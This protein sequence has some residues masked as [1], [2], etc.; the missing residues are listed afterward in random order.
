MDARPRML[1]PEQGKAQLRRNR[2]SQPDFRANCPGNPRESVPIPVQ[3]MYDPRNV[4][5]PHQ[6][7]MGRAI[8]DQPSAPS[9]PDLPH[10]GDPHHSSFAPSLSGQHF[11]SPILALCCRPVRTGMD[12][13]IHRPRL[14][15]QTAGV[16][17]RLAL[18]LRRRALV[19]GENQRQSL[20]T[21]FTEGCAILI[22]RFM[23]QRAGY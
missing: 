2:P 19:V 17:S 10:A 11:R 21:I 15:R 12:P 18:S 14:R 6:R 16:L 23:R 13:P 9:Q 3:P 7:A 20:R 1:P 8:C 5:Q 4:G 22:S